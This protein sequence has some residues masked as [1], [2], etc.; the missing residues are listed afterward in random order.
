MRKE[1]FKRLWSIILFV[2]ETQRSE[3][4]DTKWCKDTLNNGDEHGKLVGMK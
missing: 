3:D 2:K 4:K 1:D